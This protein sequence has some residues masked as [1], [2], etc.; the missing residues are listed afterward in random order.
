[1]RKLIITVIFV[2][3]II[4]WLVFSQDAEEKD[5]WKPIK[6]FIGNWTGECTGKAGDGKGERA[7]EFI[8]NGT[9]VHYRNTTRFEPQEKNPKGEVHEDWGF[10][11]YNEGRDRVIL[12]QFNIEGFVNTF[13]LD[14]LSDDHKAIVLTTESSENAPP[15]LKARYTIKIKDENEFEEIFDLGFPGREMTC[16]MK[17]TWKRIEDE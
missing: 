7:Y 15:G 12:R 4:P 17:N 13:V 3:L 6:Y 16:Y 14:S 9:Y 2:A 11:S 8:M 10:F 1:M 5:V